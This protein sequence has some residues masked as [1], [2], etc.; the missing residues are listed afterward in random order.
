MTLANHE[1][2]QGRPGNGRP[3]DG[4]QAWLAAAVGGTALL[5]GWAFYRRG[6]RTAPGGADSAPGRTSRQV[7]YGDYAVV[8]RTVTINRPR[9]DLYAFWRDFDNLAGFMEHVKRVET[10]DGIATWVLGGP[11]GT[12]I[13]VRTRIV[14]D[15]PD[16]E[17]AWRSVEG[18]DITTEGKVMFRE[19]SGGRGTEVTATIA[20]V[21][22]F[23]EAGRLAGKLFGR[24]PAVQGRRE[25]KRFKMLMETGEVATSRN[26]NAS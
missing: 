25:L 2:G 12:E 7:Y 15:R 20:Y 23:G 3:G 26:T 22:P 1:T 10:R 24:D 5:A 16:E 17:I 8:G 6:L 4:R 13:S 18:S 21:P 9:A 11:A 14:S 19:A